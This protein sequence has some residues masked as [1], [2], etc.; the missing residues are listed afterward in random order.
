MVPI[1]AVIITYN[2]ADKISRCIQSVRG[3]ADEVLVVDSGSTDDTVSIAEKSGA[4]VLQQDWLGYGRQ[5]QFAVDHALHDWV[6]CLDADEWLSDELAAQLLEEKKQPQKR[7]F[8]IPRRNR[9]LG[10][11]LK[12][13]EGYPDYSLR[14][15]DRR[16]ARWNNHPVHEAV[17]TE[18]PINILKGDLMHD[19]AENLKNYLSKQNEY[20]SLQAQIMFENGRRFSLLKMIFSP[21]L[22]FLKFY[23][24]RLGFLDGIPGFIHISIGCWNSGIKHAKLFALSRQNEDH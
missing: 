15:F 10:R 11:W 1:S 14:F 23:L 8:K 7:A 20:T 19:S 21:V 4:R 12:H 17:E 24:F 5:K 2:E 6:L 13:G 16:A 18:S 22:R 9:F 3:I